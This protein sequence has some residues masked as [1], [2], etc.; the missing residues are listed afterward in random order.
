MLKLL[1]PVDGSEFSSRALDH[2]LVKMAWLLKESE[3][4]LLNVQPPVPGGGLAASL[5]GHERMKQ[6]HQEEGM[7]ALQPAMQ[8]LDA[9]GVK[10]VHHIVVGEPGPVIAEFA[11]E[12]GCDLILMGT[13]GSSASL[14][15]G[16]VAMKVIHLAEVPVTLVK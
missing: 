16:S 12:R 9:A 13:H 3:I 6:H 15:L 8:K 10:H 14:I 11:K 4:H 2:L 5:L 1:V 7:A